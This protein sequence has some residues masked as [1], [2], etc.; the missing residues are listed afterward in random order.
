MSNAASPRKENGTA[1]AQRF[2]DSENASDLTWCYQPA[3]TY[4]MSP[5]STRHS[6]KVAWRAS[7]K[8]S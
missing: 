8:R 5:G 6:I 2:D 1:L 7:G 4:S 3:G